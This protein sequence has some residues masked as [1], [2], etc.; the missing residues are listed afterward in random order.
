MEATCQWC[1]APKPSRR[2]L[3]CSELCAYLADSAR[4]A[5]S[6][7]LTCE[8]CAARLPVR[9]GAGGPRRYCSDACKVVAR[10]RKY[11]PVPPRPRPQRR[12]VVCGDLFDA[13]GQR[14]TCS[15]EC[16]LISLRLFP[17]NPAICSV[18]GADFMGTTRQK[19]CSPRCGWV[20]ENARRGRGGHRTRHTGARRER[21][22]DAYVFER[23]GWRCHICGQKIRKNLK[24]PHPR[25]ASVDHLVPCGPQ[26]KGPDILANVRASH[27]RCNESKG[28]RAMNDQLMLIG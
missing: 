5:R 16:R 6:C 21:Y 22:D 20:A 25:S 1:G 9:L 3:Y 10:L 27:L 17:R 28:R 12:C 26:D 8:I 14:K 24:W 4:R 23:D 7:R 13:A 2:G 11:V 15:D 18:C 19:Y